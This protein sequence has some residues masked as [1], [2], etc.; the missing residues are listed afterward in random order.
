MLERD[1]Y[2][3]LVKMIISKH[4][5]FGYTTAI[6]G[7]KLLGMQIVHAK[8]FKWT[9]LFSDTL[10]RRQFDILGRLSLLIDNDKL[11]R[12][13]LAQNEISGYTDL[14][15]NEIK[16][17]RNLNFQKE[18]VF[19]VICTPLVRLRLYSLKYQPHFYDSREN[20]SLLIRRRKLKASGPFSGSVFQSSSTES[21]WEWP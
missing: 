15:Q 5:T 19:C 16:S 14:N 3:L 9:E 17:V 4:C 6:T 21:S 2:S 1:T 12:S 7:R 8:T 10:A 18:D 11:T 13:A 20:L